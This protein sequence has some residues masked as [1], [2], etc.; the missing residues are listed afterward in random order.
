LYT[1]SP[2]L[3]YGS[4]ES[5]PITG[6]SV[7]RPVPQK[8]GGCQFGKGLLSKKGAIKPM[9]QADEMKKVKKK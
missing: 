4:L 3:K 1:V 7:F 6:F 9:F 2:L 5:L 8:D